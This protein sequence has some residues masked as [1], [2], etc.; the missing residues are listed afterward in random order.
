MLRASSCLC[1]ATLLVMASDSPAGDDF[2]VPDV[3]LLSAWSAAASLML[4]EHMLEESMDSVSDR[5]GHLSGV[6][7]AIRSALGSIPYGCE[8][9][10]A[11]GISPLTSP[12]G[13]RK[14]LTAA[15]GTMLVL[16]STPRNPSTEYEAVAGSLAATASLYPPEEGGT[17]PLRLGLSVRRWLRPIASAVWMPNLLHGEIEDEK[18][19]AWA[20]MCHDL[21]AADRQHILRCGETANARHLAWEDASRTAERTATRFEAGSGPES[22]LRQL[23]FS[24]SRTT[25]ALATASAESE[26]A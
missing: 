6:S 11:A 18:C 12:T 21:I 3:G 24:I 7:A 5:A 20:D 13:V 1:R 26:A 14:E 16:T 8:V 2:G 25:A 4:V 9:A 22:A 15:A 10:E 17:A 19:S 23:G